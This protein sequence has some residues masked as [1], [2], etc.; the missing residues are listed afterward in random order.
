LIV[1]APYFG[2][3]WVVTTESGQIWLATDFGARASL[4]GG[5]SWSTPGRSE[6]GTQ[7]IIAVD[8]GTSVGDHERVAVVAGKKTQ[9]NNDCVWATDDSGQ[10]WFQFFNGPSRRSIQYVAS[11]PP[12]PDGRGRWYVLTHGELWSNEEPPR[13]EGSEGEPAVRRWAVQRLRT[14]QALGVAQD[15]AFDRL[16]LSGEEIAGLAAQQRSAQAAPYLEARLTLLTDGLASHTDQRISFP[17]LRDGQRDLTNVFFFV[18][19]T[20]SLPELIWAPN[21]PRWRGDLIELRKQVGY[22]VEDAWHERQQHLTRL[23]RGVAD[24]LEAEILRNR[25]EML[26]VVLETWTG[27]SCDPHEL[28]LER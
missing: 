9:Y 8:Y 14:S 10:T 19:G 18:Q 24:P 21:A 4:D 1:N 23:A 27:R 2:I 20:W 22:V 16:H 26:E 25:V 28:F 6:F 7:P 17:L 3:Q 15:E 13:H 5:Q 12:A 11:G